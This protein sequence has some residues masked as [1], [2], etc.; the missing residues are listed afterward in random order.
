M[1]PFYM[2]KS[3]RTNNTK[4]P[5][6]KSLLIAMALIYAATNAFADHHEEK[7][8]KVKHDKEHHHVE[9]AGDHEH[10]DEHHKDHD[11]KKHHPK[12]DEEVKDDK[13][14]EEQPKPKK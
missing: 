4:E 13:H 10:D 8:K 11:H 2:P 9:E 3:Q 5:Q 1:E 7:A 12:H 14:K 6:M